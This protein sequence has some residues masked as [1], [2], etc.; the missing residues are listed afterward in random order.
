[1]FIH[2]SFNLL[3]GYGDH[4]VFDDFLADDNIDM[5]ETLDN[6]KYEAL[7]DLQETKDFLTKDCKVQL[8]RLVF[9]CNKCLY[10]LLSF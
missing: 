1:M 5:S 6:L 4:L 8:Q 10:N 2:L 7:D 3:E 9:F